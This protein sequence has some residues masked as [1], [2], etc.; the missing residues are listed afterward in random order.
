MPEPA[1]LLGWPAA[2]SAAGDVA[3]SAVAAQSAALPRDAAGGAT[4]PRRTAGI[5]GLGAALPAHAVPNA[6]V[7]ARLGVD[8]SWIERRTGIRSRRRLG[9]DE[10]LSDL[11]AEAG[12]AALDDAGLAA[13]AIDL[14]LVATCSADELLPGTAPLVAHELGVRAGALDLNGAC[15]GFVAGLGLAAAAVEAG[16][17]ERVLLVGAEALSRLT[18]PNDRRTAGLF[19]DGAGAAVVAAGHGELGPVV[20]R[21]AGEHA[22][23]I[24]ATRA[25]PVIR[26]E[27]HETFLEATAALAEATQA[28]CLAAGLALADADLL[29]FH[30]ANRRILDAVADRLALDRTKVVDAIADAGNTSAASVPLALAQAR[31]EGRLRRGDRVVLGAMGAG[32]TSGAGVLTW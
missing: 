10:R 17:A 28:A 32:F 2:G 29:V 11:A 12:R 18:D 14:V 13:S 8:A 3:A 16:R 4:A 27:G 25:D 7:A 26:M 6:D 20:L 19:G 30:Q 5:A 1:A 21:S 24:R 9:P 22:A 31:G 15:T 23:L